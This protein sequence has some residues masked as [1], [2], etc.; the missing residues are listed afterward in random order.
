YHATWLALTF[1]AY[2]IFVFVMPPMQSNDEPSHWNRLWSVA[3]GHLTCGDIPM[4]T[5]DFVGAVHYNEVRERNW[6]WK[7]Q[8][9]E[10]ART[11]EGR[12]SRHKAT[13]NACVYIP[14]AYVLPALAM[15]PAV[16]PYDPRFPAGMLWGYYLARF[17][18]VLLL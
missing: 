10:D 4:V 15:L 13:G 12:V 1:C 16:S 11:L 18:N 8:Y 3:S 14:I 17:T 9:L 2:V 5:E 7:T 6:G